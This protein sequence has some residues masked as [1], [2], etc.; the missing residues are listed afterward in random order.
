VIDR[1]SARRDGA[2]SMLHSGAS[3]AVRFLCHARCTP[4]TVFAVLITLLAGCGGGGGGGAP[5]PPTPPPSIS[6]QPQ[7]LTV[8]AGQPATFTVVA[9]GATAYQWSRNGQ[10]INGATNASYALNPATS[11]N[12]GDTYQ[13][14]VSNSGGTINSATAMLRVTGVAVVAGQP[15]GMGYQDGAAAQ[16]RFWGPVALAFD[17]SGNLFV[18]DYNAVREIDT[19]GNVSTVVGSPRICGS[20][21]GTGAAARLCYPYSLATDASGNVYAGDN[22]GVV[23]KISAG[24]SSVESAAFLCPFGLTILG[25]ALYVSDECAGNITQI[26]GATSSSYA[27]TGLYPLGLSSDGVGTLYIANDTVVQSVTPGPPVTVNA[28]AG[29]ANSPG[30]V[31]G[32]GSAVRFGCATYPYPLSIGTIGPFYGVFGIATTGAGLSYVSDYCNN[33]VRTVDSSGTVSAFAGT[34]GAP[35]DA[36]GLGG[37]ANFWAPAGMALD[38]TGNVYVADYGNA[39]IRKITPAG[40]VSTYAGMTPHFGSADG[41]G[42]AASFR[43]PRG[44]AADASGNVYVADSNHTI[45]KITAAGVVSTL[46]GFAGLPGSRDGTGTTAQ[47]FLPKGLGAD[48]TGNLYVA[49]SGNYTV[50]RVTPAGVV[51]TFAGTAGSPGLVNG[52]GSAAR[53]KSPDSVAVDSAGDVFVSDGVVVRVITPTAQVSTINAMAPSTIEG[54]AVDAAG[55]TVYLTT[56]TAVYSLTRPGVLTA[57]AGGNSTG[58]ADGTGTAA[59]FNNPRGLVLGGDGNLYVADQQNSTIRKVTLSGV[60]TTSIGTPAIPMGIVPGG[61]PGRLGAPWGLA[62]LSSGASVSLAITEEWE[63]VVLRADLP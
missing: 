49:D 37:A 44:I 40:E 21:A 18:A 1:Y 54:I 60:V 12:N 3:R 45:R 28:L 34:P 63:S 10:D 5:P 57:I 29:L 2:Y 55:A 46:A 43:Y 22:D 23:W 26:Q 4:S 24:V 7:S 6:Q 36:N 58:S 59:A 61:L 20:T 27:I 16:A 41:T 48:S 25:A 9:S 50:R 62:L 17:G 52:Q 8:N 15:G 31:N 47:F 38:S 11:Q 39:L 51:S 33:S 56:S 53:F 35:G 13:V 19:G 32:T 14:A 42:S 30:A